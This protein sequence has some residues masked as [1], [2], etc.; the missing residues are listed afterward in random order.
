MWFIFGP[1]E[2]Y[3]GNVNQFVFGYKDFFFIMTGIGIVGA[4]LLS[5][6]I[7]AFPDKLQGIMRILLCS[8]SVGSYIQVMWLNSG[9]DL[10]GVVAESNDIS[11]IKALKN[12]LV[13]FLVLAVIS[14]LAIKIKNVEKKITNY[15]SAFLLAVQLVALVTLIATADDNAFAKSYENVSYISDEGQFC[16]SSQD[17]IIVIVLDFF[18]NQYIEPM[19][20]EYPEALDG[21]NDFTYYDNADCMY[22]GTFPSLAHLATGQ[23]LDVAVPV[24]E[25][26]SNIWSCPETR[27]YYSSLQ[28]AGYRCRFYT[29]DQTYLCG[30][31]DVEILDG[32]ID[33]VGIKSYS[34]QVNLSKLLK[35]LTKMG[36]Y[37]M[38]PYIMKPMFYTSF[39]NKYSMIQKPEGTAVVSNSAYFAKIIGGDFSLVDDTKYYTFQHLTGDHFLST[40][41][42][43]TETPSPTLEENSAGCMFIMTAYLNMLKE[44][45]IYDNATIIITSDHGGPRDSQPILFVK[46]A[47]EK[48]DEMEVSHAPVSFAEFQ[49][50]I[51]EA[52]GLD[53]SCYGMTFSDVPFGPRERIVLVREMHAELPK[54]K[55]YDA[56]QVSTLNSYGVYKYR[57]DVNEL[58]NAYDA[59]AESVIHMVDSFY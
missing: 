23:E 38:V 30:T 21:F 12:G 8:F 44:M 15:I 53:V 36:G 32:C 34:P 41:S 55:K 3:M 54:V 4:V 43:G 31:N 1:M 46:K 26:F 9:I 20:E 48:H 13:W 5:L 18:S 37:R 29:D 52:A 10:L 24:N 22:F 51:V 7:S 58:L 50:T 42:D 19:L 28:N 27:G 33:N 25:W 6:I 45:G 40:A 49:A 59:G 2:I 11:E 39:D 14:V 35:N 56:K 57:G 16:L 17:N 47:G